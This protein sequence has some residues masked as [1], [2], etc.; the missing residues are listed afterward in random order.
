MQPNIDFGL[1]VRFSLPLSAFVALTMILSALWAAALT[2][3]QLCED[4]D[5]TIFVP[6]WDNSTL[7]KEYPS[8]VGKEGATVQ[9]L[10]GQF[11]YS[12]GNQLLG[13]L[14]ASASSATTIDGSPR[15]HEKL[16]KSK[17]TYIGRSYGIGSSI[18]VMD[19]EILG[20]NLVLGYAF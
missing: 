6:N 17:F 10:K 5:Q 2:P 16:D 15:I 19:E 8:E 14:L 11:S 20:N 13:S 1:P 7:I 3:V 9:N 18:G 12:V 4:V